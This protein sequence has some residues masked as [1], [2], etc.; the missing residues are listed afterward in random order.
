MDVLKEI[1][2]QKYRVMNNNGYDY[3]EFLASN[4]REAMM[5]VAILICGY[6]F[7]EAVIYVDNNFFYA[8]LVA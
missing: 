3:G 7:D 8:E 5:N 1:V 4:E 2:M 6:E